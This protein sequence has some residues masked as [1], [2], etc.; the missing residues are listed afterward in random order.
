[1]T[2]LQAIPNREFKLVDDTVQ[3]PEWDIGLEILILPT[4]I[5][6]VMAGTQPV[7]E[8]WLARLFWFYYV[9]ILICSLPI[10]VDLWCLKK[11]NATMLR[12]VKNRI[13]NAISHKS[14]P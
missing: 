10:I 6:I 1:M 4:I 13:W 14:Q 7:N 3:M 5:G 8:G 12:C 2:E 11:Y 9:Y